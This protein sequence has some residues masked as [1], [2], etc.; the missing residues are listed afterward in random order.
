MTDTSEAYNQNRLG[1]YTYLNQ[2]NI[3]KIPIKW[4]RKNESVTSNGV[5]PPNPSMSVGKFNSN[6]T[7]YPLFQIDARSPYK[8][9]YMVNHYGGHETKLGTNMG[10]K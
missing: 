5:R 2:M 6:S 8:V 1:Y 9:Q 3:N 10:S 7:A 4:N